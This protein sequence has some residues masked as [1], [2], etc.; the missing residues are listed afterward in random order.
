MLVLSRKEQEEIV[1]D[2]NVVIRVLE[3]R[4]DRVRLGITA[5]KEISVH[6]REIYD[7]L[8]LQNLTVPV[9]HEVTV[10]L[11]PETLTSH[12]DQESPSA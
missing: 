4:K 7:R 10:S 6:R 8:A 5:P 1:I 12:S 2:T 3:V 9:E 11:S